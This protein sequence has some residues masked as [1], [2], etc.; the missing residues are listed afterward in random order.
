MKKT[1]F[2]IGIAIT[3]VTACQ[4]SS[5]QPSNQ[6]N[7]TSTKQ[8]TTAN[9]NQKKH[10]S[11]SNNEE[12]ETAGKLV[13]N[14]GD[15]WQAN[16]ETTEGI[17]NMLTMVNEYLKKGDTDNKK[18]S[19]GLENEFSTI[20][21]KCTMTGLAH[22]QLHNFL[23]PFKEKIEKLKGTKDIETVKEIQSYL[24]NYFNYFE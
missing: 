15:K 12:A 6:N 21:Q 10:E 8:D 9:L 18:L 7:G 13:L 5:N 2:L 4:N 24:N 14:N 23:L 20:L 3:L 19:V 11:E 17:K 22:E 1:V 16:A